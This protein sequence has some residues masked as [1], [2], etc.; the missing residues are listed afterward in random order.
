MVSDKKTVEGTTRPQVHPD[1]AGRRASQEDLSILQNYDTVFVIDGKAC[2]S[3]AFGKIRA[4]DPSRFQKDSGS[5]EGSRWKQA[6]EALQEVVEMAVKWDKN[7]VDIHFLN[8]R[9]SVTGCTVCC[10]LPP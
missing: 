3:Y 7:G 10:Q 9:K 8:S 6:R 1:V 2:R 5:M 4:D